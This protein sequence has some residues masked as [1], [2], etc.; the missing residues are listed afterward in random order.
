VALK[1]EIMLPRPGYANSLQVA[2]Q[3]IDVLPMELNFIL[4][5]LLNF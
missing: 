3:F 5:S 2:Q 1:N 4:A